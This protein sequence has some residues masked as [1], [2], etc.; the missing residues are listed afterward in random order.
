MGEDNQKEDRRVRRTKKLLMQG[1]TQLMQQKQ[2]RDITVREL[3]DMVDVN[4][5]TFYIHYKDIFDMLEKIE[6]EL[7]AKFDSIMVSHKDETVINHIKPFLSDLCQFIDENQGMCRVLLG[8]NGDMAFLHRLNAVMR[9]KIHDDWKKLE[10][11]GD[12]TEFEY[13]YSFVLF[14]CIGI[15]RTWL[16][17][18]CKEETSR[19][20]ELA[21]GMIRQGGIPTSD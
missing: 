18:G 9:E 8:Q 6:A 1:L 3:A 16:E 13:R 14:G 12:D 5:G 17:S 11:K 21:D 7:F 2:L 4:R 10:P 20:V 19:L 15:L